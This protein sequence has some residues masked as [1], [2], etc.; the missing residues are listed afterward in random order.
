MKALQLPYPGPLLA[1]S[2]HLARL[3]MDKSVGGTST[4]EEETRQQKA[5]QKER[6]K[7]HQ[8]V[9]VREYENL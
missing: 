1:M 9:I 8:D 6:Q 3:V 4:S 2:Y 5:L 7:T